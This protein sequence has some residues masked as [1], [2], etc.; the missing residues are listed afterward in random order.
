[1]SKIVTNQFLYDMFS[2]QVFNI[3]YENFTIQ[4]N[5]KFNSYS[6]VLKECNYNYEN[7]QILLTYRL[8]TD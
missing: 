4:I 8:N 2:R 1:M 7:K 5:N 3:D 6:F